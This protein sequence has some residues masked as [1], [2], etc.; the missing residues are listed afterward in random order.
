VRILVYG[1]GVI[2][3]FNAARLEAAGHEVALLARGP[4]LADLREH[5][6][7][8]ENARS[9]ERT[10]T[11]VPLV[12]ALA[13]D[14]AYDLVL[15]TLRRNQVPAILPALAANARTPIVLFLGNNAAGADEWV[16]A[17]GRERVLL[18]QAN[19]GGVREGHVVRYLWARWLPLEFSELDDRRTA[20]TAAIEDAFR[21][22][23]ISARTTKHQDASL[24]T[25][26]A[27]LV[28]IAGALYWAGGDVRRLAHARRALRLWVRATREGLRALERLGIPI[29]PPA[30]RVV[31]WIP[32]SLLAF[33]M[34][35][36]LDTE[37]AVVGLGGH[38]NAAPDEMKELAD[39]FRDLLRRAGLPSPA[40]DRLYAHIDAAYAAW[41]GPDEGPMPA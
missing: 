26:A 4:R 2:G 25:H 8:L 19:L 9:G 32:E 20:R 5:G 22:A 31:E 23:G 30:L 1:A 13:P 6:V 38:G 15:V 40:C 34:G 16:A 21:L 17:L 12:D 39:E 28:P 10:T 11:E 33:G 41:R 37:L 29:V 36:F 18:G 14:D 3:S 27:S 7:V 24:K 35:R